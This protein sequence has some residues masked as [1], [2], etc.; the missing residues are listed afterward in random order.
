MKKK[1]EV[2]LESWASAAKWSHL[3]HKITKSKKSEPEIIV[4]D[5]ETVYYCK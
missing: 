2:W 4:S 3:L 5:D 1:K